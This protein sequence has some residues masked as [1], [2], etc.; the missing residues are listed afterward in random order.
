MFLSGNQEFILWSKLDMKWLK[1]IY[2]TY[3][4]SVQYE[5]YNIFFCT[6][7]L[8]GLWLQDSTEDMNQQL[9]TYEKHSATSNRLLQQRELTSEMKQHSITVQLVYSVSSVTEKSVAV[10]RDPKA[11]HN[12]SRSKAEQD[13]TKNK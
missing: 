7:T 3:L 1:A 10:L 8:S 2:L 6:L 11:W 4:N 5:K 9:H 13:Q 12:E